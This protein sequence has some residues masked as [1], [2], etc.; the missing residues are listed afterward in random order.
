MAKIERG[1]LDGVYG[2]RQRTAD[3]L[4]AWADKL[5]AEASNPRSKD[6]PRWVLRWVSTIRRLAD[7]KAAS[8][9]QARR[10]TKRR[11]ADA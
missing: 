7:Q 11:D 3:E 10:R 4:Y 2:M 6:D 9:T 8:H 1:R 5:E